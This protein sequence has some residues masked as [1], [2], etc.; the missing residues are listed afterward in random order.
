DVGEAAGRP[1]FVLEFVAGGSLAQHL[2]GTPQPA[3]PAAQLVETL[4][5]A[6][7]AAHA[8]GVIHR[9]LQPANILLEGSGVRGRSAGGTAPRPPRPRPLLARPPSSPTSAW[10]SAPAA[11]GRRRSSAVRRSPG[12]C[13]ARPITWPPN[14]RWSPASRLAR[15][16]MST[17]WEPSSMSC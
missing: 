5:W 10:P 6:V 14:R 12:N 11:K 7:H 13:W 1:Y 15:P 4:A 8:N 9:D 17:P 2:Q 16:R 3:R